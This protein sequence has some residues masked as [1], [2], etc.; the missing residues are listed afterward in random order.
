[1]DNKIQQCCT[2]Y[3]IYYLAKVELKQ[4]HKVSNEFRQFEDEILIPKITKSDHIFSLHVLA[5]FKAN[6]QLKERLLTSVDLDPA[7][8]VRVVDLLKEDARNYYNIYLYCLKQ[9]YKSIIYDHKTWYMVED[10]LS[11]NKNFI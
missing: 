10:K 11:F 6:A 1:M 9:H 3:E 8:G 2:Y 4:M 7:M 5:L